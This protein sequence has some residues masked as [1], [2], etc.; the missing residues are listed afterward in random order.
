LEL[1]Q[2][3]STDCE[4]GQVGI[5]PFFLTKIGPHHGHYLVSWFAAPAGDFDS[6]G[7]TNILRNGNGDKGVLAAGRSWWM[8]QTIC[9]E[10][11]FLSC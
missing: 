8:G 9:P 4:L 6:Q 7:N 1:L 3:S 10:G 2:S 5:I 11:A